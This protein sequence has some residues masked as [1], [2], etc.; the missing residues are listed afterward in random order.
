MPDIESVPGSTSHSYLWKLHIDTVIYFALWHF[1]LTP[2]AR[3]SPFC[4]LRT[5][6]IGSET[7]V[8]AMELVK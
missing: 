4:Y 1:G 8:L 3:V 6:A 5:Y 2:I 7:M